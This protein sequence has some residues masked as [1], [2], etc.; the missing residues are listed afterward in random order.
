MQ[1]NRDSKRPDNVLL[2]LGFEDAEELAAKA[3][4]ALKINELVSERGLSQMEAAGIIG[5]PQPKI[6]QIRNYKLR[7]ISLERLMLALTALGQ[8]VKIVV[9]PSSA[10]V[11]PRISVAA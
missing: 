7:N 10:R 1:R 3:T 11:S 8:N 6:S 9:S 4:L 2:D 5:M